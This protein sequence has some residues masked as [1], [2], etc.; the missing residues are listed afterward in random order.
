VQ[1]PDCGT[2]GMTLDA[3]LAQISGGY[4]W[5][6]RRYANE[7]SVEDRGRYE[8]EEN[9][10]RLRKRGLWQDAKAIPPWE[11]RQRVPGR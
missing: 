4:A 3:G 1:P 5:W 11:W 9:E 6:F 7:Q 2:C 8:S 10:A